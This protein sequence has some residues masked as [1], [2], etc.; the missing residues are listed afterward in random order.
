MAL[1][2]AVERVEALTF[3]VFGTVVDWRSSII[4]ELQAFGAAKGISADWAE[5]TDA[6]RGLYQPQLAR[7]REGALPWTKLDDLHRTSL[8]ELLVR[9]DIHGLSESEKDHVNRVWHRLD[10]WPDSL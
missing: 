7:V 3:D 4:R 6:W 10:P 8:E 5:L 9:F 2:Q 1:T